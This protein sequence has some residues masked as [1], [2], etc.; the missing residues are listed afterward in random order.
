V[1]KTDPQIGRNLR[2]R[3]MD[4]RRPRIK[5][6]D[7]SQYLLRP[8]DVDKLIDENHPARAIWEFVGRLDLEAFYD[9]IEVKEGEPGRAAWDPKLMIALWVYAYSAGIGSA[10]EVERR[11]EFDP[12]FQW[13]T[14][15]EVINHHSLS[16]FRIAEKERLDE[17]FRQTL[18]LLAADG[19]IEME[20]IAHDGTKIKANASGK[21]FR[22][23]KRLRVYLKLAEEQLKQLGDPR[24]DNYTSKQEKAK[25]RARREKKEKLEHALK[26]LENLKES[27]SDKRG[28]ENI[29]VSITDPE[30]R[31][32][33]QPDG[34][35]L[36][37][38][39]AQL[40][41]DNKHGIVIGVG[42]SNSPVDWPELQPA[43]DRIE[44]NMGRLPKQM[45]V[46]GGYASHENITRIADTNVELFSPM[47]QTTTFQNNAAKTHAIEEGF[48]KDKFKYDAASDS[49]LCPSGKSIKL[50]G[51][52]NRRGRESLL[53]RANRR[54]CFSC[55][56]KPQCCPKA[57][58]GRSL[59]VIREAPEVYAF[60]KKME[61]DWAK[62]IYRTRA[63]IAEFSNAWLK[64]KIGLRQFC[65]MGLTKAHMELTWACMAM[66]LQHWT[67]LRWQP[68]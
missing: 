26:E 3:G 61:E 25:E 9:S 15:M 56:S 48:T 52:T 28:K 27:K 50:Y 1:K 58:T 53:Y 66:N 24:E 40:S 60:K 13:L 22:R 47:M 31:R 16:D 62:Q 59:Q 51:K 23:E 68:A 30:A 54:D 64:A 29:R 45:V 42:V 57:K 41:T 5:T 37:S 43:L 49:Y 55:P 35:F 4:K 21:T 63:P 39:N 32:M 44:S 12:A 2:K 34:G 65:V 18:G 7:R 67:R 46:D 20:R 19:L 36:P 33:K 17:L 14:G 10:R 38:Y 6:V 11:C 8:T